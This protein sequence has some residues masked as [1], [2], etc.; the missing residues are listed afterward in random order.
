MYVVWM[1][2]VTRRFVPIRSLD[3]NWVEIVA[4]YPVLHLVATLVGYVSAMLFGPDGWRVR[5][6][7]ARHGPV[8]GPFWR[9]VAVLNVGGVRPHRTG[10]LTRGPVSRG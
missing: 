3:I 6:I 1:A 8:R 9:W 2:L 10:A 5:D 4:V 7:A